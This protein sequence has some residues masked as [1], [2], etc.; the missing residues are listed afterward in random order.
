MREHLLYID[1]RWRK[2]GGGTADATSPSSGE[3]FASVAVADS[4]D[5][6]EAVA[7]DVVAHETVSG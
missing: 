3:T 6:G 4:A 5:V 7:A 2:G 1:G